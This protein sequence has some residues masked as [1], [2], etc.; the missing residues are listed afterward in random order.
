[1]LL[2]V[3]KFIADFSTVALAIAGLIGLVRY[4]R[5][6][7]AMRYLLLLTLL[8]LGVTAVATWLQ[9][10]HRPNLFLFPIDTAIEFTLLALIYRHTLSELAVSRFIP[11][12]VAVFLL[13]TALT[14]RPR[15]DTVEFSPVQHFIEGVVV[16]AFVLLYFR[17]EI[18]RRVVTRRLELDPMFWVSTGLLLYFSGNLLIFLT[19][20]LVLKYSVAISRHVWAI[21][22][23]LYTFLNVFYSIAFSLRPQSPQAAAAA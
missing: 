1:M 4:R 5:L 14:Y 19:S 15:L 18:T 22:A 10:Q 21:H 13:G 20:N 12:M 23:L 7:G 6:N 17:R 9:R 3:E 2:A 11:A 16:L 8:A